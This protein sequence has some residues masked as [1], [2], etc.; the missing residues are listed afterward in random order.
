[1]LLVLAFS[2]AVSF[3]SCS[4][5]DDGGSSSNLSGSLWI[6]RWAGHE[7]ESDIVYFM[8]NTEVI[9]L[10][11]DASISK[12]KILQM[13]NGDSKYRVAKY[14]YN[15]DTKTV[16]FSFVKREK[17]HNCVMIISEDGKKA[18]FTETTISEGHT[19]SPYTATLTK[20]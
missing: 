6:Y 14:T 9:Y 17:T 13:A 2:A 5:D 16:T 7:D 19:S 8:S 18:Q 11:D 4:S 20:E 1:M 10:I 15:A 3:T 12:D